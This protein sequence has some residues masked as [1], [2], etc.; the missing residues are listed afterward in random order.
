MSNSIFSF[1]KDTPSFNSGLNFNFNPVPTPPFNWNTF[2]SQQQTNIVPT[3]APTN[4]NSNSNSTLPN[5]FNFQNPAPT[6]TPN[7]TN[8]NFQNQAQPQT[9]APIPAPGPTVSPFTFGIFGTQQQPPEPVVDHK[10]IS[11]NFVQQ[12]YTLYDNNPND[13]LKYFTDKAEITYFDNEFVGGNKLLEY[14]KAQNINNF[15]HENI[16]FVSKPTKNKIIVLISGH[17]HV[18]IRQQPTAYSFDNGEIK[19]FI[20]FSE[21]VVLTKVNNLYYISTLI[22]KSN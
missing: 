12:Y 1:N 9:Q 7:T 11:K 16:T 18:S 17:L 19:K 22:T 6:P 13:L 20:N 14:M 15:K 5:I 3:P 2:A 8:F 21:L 10:E 4:T